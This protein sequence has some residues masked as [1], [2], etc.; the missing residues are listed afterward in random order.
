MRICGCIRAADREGAAFRGHPQSR[1]IVKVSMRSLARAFTLI[2]LLIVVAIIAILA[3]IAV[4][5]FLEAQV[6]SKVARVRAD[7][8]TMATAIESYAVDNAL[9]SP[10]FGRGRTM[11]F[12]SPYP[13]GTT[14]TETLR[15]RYRWLTTPIAYLEAPLPDPY[16]VG[17]MSIPPDERVLV[18]WSEPIFRQRRLLRLSQQELFAEHPWRNTRDLWAAFSGGPDADYDLTDPETPTLGIQSFDPTN[19]LASDG[20]ILRGRQ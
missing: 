6:R 3:A 1:R 17:N 19:G 9:P 5:N 11:R 20:D 13:H 8:R 7:Q 18:I 15:T 4:P 14:M 16:R 12:P 10:A 2:E